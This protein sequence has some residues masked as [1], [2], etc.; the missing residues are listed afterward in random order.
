[1]KKDGAIGVF[2]SGIG[3]LT[4]VKGIMDRLPYE[5]VVYFGDTARVPYGTKSVETINKFTAQIVEFLLSHEVKALVVAC[6]TISAVALDTVYQLAGDIPV[7]DVISSGAKASVMSTLN[8]NIGVIATNA[9]VNSNAYTRAIYQLDNQSRVYAKA[10][11]LFVPFVEEGLLD[12]PALELIARDYLNVLEHEGIDTLILGCTHYPL[13]KPL[14]RKIMHDKINII[15]SSLVASEDLA[16][17]LESTGLATEVNND[18][19]IEHKFYVSDVPAKFQKMAESF[20]NRN[21][22]LPQLVNL[23]S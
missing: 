14:I 13:I 6:N 15:D 8:H 4:V 20:L 12:H 16:I 22:P 23:D 19:I 5:N 10:C 17:L 2:D 7:I 21:M 9:T 11:P 3:G 1:M 18:R